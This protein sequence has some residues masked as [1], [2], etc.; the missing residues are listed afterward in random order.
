MPGI[1]KKSHKQR[2]AGKGLPG[3]GWRWEL[4]PVVQLGRSVWC[5]GWRVHSGE[6]EDRVLQAHCV[7]QVVSS[8][9][10]G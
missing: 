6:G 10:K 7:Q 2:G 4:G 8:P 1:L 3:R 9:R 5:A